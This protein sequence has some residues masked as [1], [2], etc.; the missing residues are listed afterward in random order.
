MWANTVDDAQTAVTSLGGAVAGAAAERL[1]SSA[2]SLVGLHTK[3]SLGDIG[4]RFMVR[5][6]VSSAVYGAAVTAMPDTSQN[7]LFTLFYFGANPSLG[8]EAAQI[9]N[10]VVGGIPALTKLQGISPKA[11][12]PV[13]GPDPRRGCESGC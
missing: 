2:I 3:N 5:A 9:G 11:P 13:L 4:L 8:R 10:I 12:M 6:L 7:I 1:G